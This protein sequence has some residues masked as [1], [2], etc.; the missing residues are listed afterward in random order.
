MK[1]KTDIAYDEQYDYAGNIGGE[2]SESTHR[3][4]AKAA[5]S[6]INNDEKVRHFLQ[7]A[8]LVSLTQNPSGYCI[9]ESRGF[10]ISKSAVPTAIGNLCLALRRA[11]ILTFT[12]NI[13]VMADFYL[14]A[15]ATVTVAYSPKHG[16][17]DISLHLLRPLPEARHG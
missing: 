12:D 7:T 16:G 13:V 3:T 11:P 4:N 10:N 17:A 1:V 9:D 14:S 6:N 2:F 15:R 5:I 8:S